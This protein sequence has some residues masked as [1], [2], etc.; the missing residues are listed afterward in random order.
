MIVNDTATAIYSALTSGTQVTS[1]LA[2]T[3]SIYHMQAPDN[4]NLPYVVF[5]LQAGGPEL[6]NPSKLETNTWW[7]RVYSV[8]SASNAAQIF[9]QVDLKLNR[10]NISITGATTIQCVRD[11]NIALVENPPK[12]IPI[13]TCGGMYRIR[14]TNT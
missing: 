3:T 13:Y 12:G 5:S 10:V 9:E 2:G 14:T 1:L 7:I 4:S 6:I 8:T 11:G